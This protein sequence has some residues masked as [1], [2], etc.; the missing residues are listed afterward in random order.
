MKGS[1]FVMPFSFTVK[2]LET[3]KIKNKMCLEQ[4]RVH[5]LYKVLFVFINKKDISSK[6]WQ[7]RTDGAVF[8]IQ[9]L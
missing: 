5:Q 2:L 6:N 1:Y 7:I 3:K 9:K 4:F 8:P